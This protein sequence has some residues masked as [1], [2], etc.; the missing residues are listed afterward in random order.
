[1]RVL[2]TGVTGFVGTHLADRLRE[3]GLEVHG[4]ASSGGAEGRA[5]SERAWHA[6][7]TDREALA[8]AVESSDPE[9]VVHLA[10]LSHVGRSWQ[11]PQDYFRVNFQGTC[12]V[13]KAAG[14]RRVIFASSAEVYGTVPD[15]EQPI[16]ESR[17]AAPRSPYAITKACA[18]DVALDHGAVVVR[19]FNSIGPGQSRQFALP[20]FA[21][22][23][24]AI[25]AG[26]TEPVLSVGDL[27]PQ[28][29]F[30]HVA[31]A[32][33]AYEL[34]LTEGKGG[35]IYNLATGEVSTIADALETLREISGVEADIQV[36]PKR[37]R[38]VDIPLTH[39]DP[40]KLKAL[41]WQP[42][43]DLRRA[44]EDLWQETLRLEGETP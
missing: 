21:G 36:D 29:D 2:I 13:L 30:L 32:V 20:S 38:P 9:V 40:T 18:E 34:L 10:G 28:R 24:A 33:S 35:E 11:V 6:D 37:V 1:M 14:K 44:L 5:R 3:A 42:R 26:R 23:L 16:P 25:R 43:Y 41:G 22:Q 19:S 15:A 17:A 31:D 8:H 27:S 39:G 7:I 12:N 4:L